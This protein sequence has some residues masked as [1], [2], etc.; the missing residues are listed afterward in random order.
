MKIRHKW[1]IIEYHSTFFFPTY[2]IFYSTLR[3]LSQKLPY[4]PVDG[5]TA[6]VNF[7]Y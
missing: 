4:C 7:V 3:F 6:V 5:I 2:I 1:L